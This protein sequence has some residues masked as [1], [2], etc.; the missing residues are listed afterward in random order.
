MSTDL[1]PADVTDLDVDLAHADHPGDVT[2]HSAAVHLS[3]EGNE[4]PLR[5]QVCHPVGI[6]V[7]A[8]LPTPTTYEF[9]SLR[10]ATIRHIPIALQE[11][12]SRTQ[13]G[14][15]NPFCSNPSELRLWGLIAMPKLV[16]RVTKTPGKNTAAHQQG[17]IR[18]RLQQLEQ[19][20]WQ[21]MW[22][23]P[24]AESSLPEGPETRSAKRA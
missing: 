12:W 7:P 14:I 5:I 6:K 19:G 2:G 1:E 3:E 23:T 4:T 22:E 20:E 8:A 21:A 24:K 17:L 10:V 11:N 15:L 13:A 9:L 16:L 18:S